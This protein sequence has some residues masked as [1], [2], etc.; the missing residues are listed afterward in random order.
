MLRFVINLDRATD[1]MDHMRRA[2]ANLGIDVE[3]VSAVDG[4]KLSP[5][6]L[7]ELQT[8]VHDI[9]KI[10]CP[11]TLTSGEVGAFLSHQECWKR[12]VNSDQKWALILEDDL[13]FS[14]RAKTYFETT[15][16]VPSGIDLV[17]FFLFRRNW[18][19]KVDKKIIKLVNGD[20]LSHPYKPSPV[21][22]QAY[23]ISRNAAENAL[24]LSQTMMAPVDEFLFN[25][26]SN[27][28]RKFPVYRLNPAV[29]IP[30]DDKLPSTIDAKKE[31]VSISLMMKYH[32]QL[33]L[34]RLQLRFKVFFNSK[35]EHFIFK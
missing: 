1:R 3:R 31:D 26:V 7:K 6:H 18:T 23:L 25:P 32:P 30:L 21:G 27:F 34:R 5:E 14:P 19:A 4:K 20:S 24:K 15:E 29:V 17:Q 16:W 33:R 12:L 13:A 22:A 9:S 28:A 8:P 2:I 10:I 35:N 11:R